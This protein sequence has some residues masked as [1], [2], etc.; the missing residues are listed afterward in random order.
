MKVRYCKHINPLYFGGLCGA[1]KGA[2]LLATYAL[3]DFDP[4]MVGLNYFRKLP[5][6]LVEIEDGLTPLLSFLSGLPEYS[7][8]VK[9]ESLGIIYLEAFRGWVGKERKTVASIPSQDCSRQH[10]VSGLFSRLE[11]LLT[12]QL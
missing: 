8:E 2:L 9:A 7:K 5:V 1:E 11:N 6:A 4:A 10:G 12:C 3:S